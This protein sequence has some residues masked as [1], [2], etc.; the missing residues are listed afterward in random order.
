MTTTESNAVPTELD[1]ATR[2]LVLEPG[3]AEYVVEVTGFNAA[4]DHQ[5]AAILVAA[6][7]DDVA[8]A[9]RIAS[10]AGLKIAVK[11]TGHSAVAAGPDTILISTRALEKLDIDHHGRTATIGAGVVWQRVLD[12][13][14]PFGLAGLAGSA[15]TVGAVGYTLGGGLSPIARTYGFAADHVRSIQVVTADGVVRRAD[16]HENAD[17]FWA[18]R[19]G[20]AAFGIVTEIVVDLFPIQTVLGGGIFFDAADARAVVQAWRLWVPTLPES[21]TTSIAVLHLPPAPEL[22]EPLRGRTVLHLRFTHVSCTEDGYAL[23]APMRG[24]AEPIIDTIAEI[25][26]PAIAAVHMDPTEPIPAME[27]G[28]L[29]TELTDDA[30]DIFLGATEL[31]LA[32]AELRAMGGALGR[33]PALANAV[34]GRDAAF[35]LFAIGVLVP[36]MADVVPGALDGFVG[37][38]E[39]WSCGAFVN[40]AGAA[41]GAPADRVRAA[42]D[43]ETRDRLARIRADVDPQNL[44]SAAAR[45]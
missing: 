29:L 2:G 17:L 32:I 6:D 34:A 15:T 26:F 18:L 21:V 43:Q 11:C 22:P 41:T 40:M 5:P 20:G 1:L 7:A 42:W 14:A 37:Q 45:W 23:L 9:V 25:P 33:L 44:F 35:N 30:V 13:A 39:P 10:R 28:M 38:F 8:A 19:G 12:A 24:I 16:E 31:P 27:R 4:V 3:T 36:P